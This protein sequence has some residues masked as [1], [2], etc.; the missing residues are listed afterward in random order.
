MKKSGFTIAELLIAVAVIGVVAVMAIPTFVH[1][2]QDKEVAA[3]LNLAQAILSNATE[4]AQLNNGKLTNSDLEKMTEKDIFNTFYK[5]T[6]KLTAFC[7][8]D[9]SETCWSQTSD[10]FGKS[11]ATG[12]DILGITGNV[13]TGFVLQDGMNITMTKVQNLDEKF[14]IDTKDEYSI[15]FMVDINGEKSPN[16]I[17]QDVFAFIMNKKGQIIPAGKD[18]DSA[19]C[20]KGCDLD[21]DY[22]DC[23][24]KVLQDEKRNYI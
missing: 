24:A 8:E 5:N 20:Q 22:W 15:V 14:G 3:K 10:F 9:T 13:H 2:K 21:D 4:M 16:A 17:G 7:S 19:N 11:K 1:A 18:N 12:G 23:S 6:L